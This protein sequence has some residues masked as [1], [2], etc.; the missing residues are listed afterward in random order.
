MSQI[1]TRVADGD[2]EFSARLARATFGST[3]VLAG[4]N[5]WLI[6]LRP[7]EDTHCSCAVPLRQA[8]KSLISLKGGHGEGDPD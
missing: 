6:L 1:A 3:G 5:P 7:L 2:W 8:Q 4:N